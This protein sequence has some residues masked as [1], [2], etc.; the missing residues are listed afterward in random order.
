MNV[1]IIQVNTGNGCT[2]MLLLIIH[3]TDVNQFTEVK[4]CVFT[5]F[6]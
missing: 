5:N 3:D 2:T 4:G 6:K 1:Y